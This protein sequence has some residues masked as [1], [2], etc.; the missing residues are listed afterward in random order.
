MI[1]DFVF[2]DVPRLLAGIE[3]R[4]VELQWHDAHSCGQTWVFIT[5]IWNPAL[6]RMTIC[7]AS[8]SLAARFSR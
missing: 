7:T 2:D 3:F 5:Q 6:S 8:G 4:A 1:G